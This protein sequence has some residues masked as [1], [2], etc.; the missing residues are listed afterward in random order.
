MADPMELDEEAGFEGGAG[1]DEED[2]PVVQTLDVFLSQVCA[3]LP[4]IHLAKRDLSSKAWL[5]QSTDF[6]QSR[7]QS[8]P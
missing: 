5:A 3:C 7:S 1:A 6:G 4:A 8:I 2:D